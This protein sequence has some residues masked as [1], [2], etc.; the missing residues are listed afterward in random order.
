M[1]TIHLAIAASVSAVLTVAAPGLAQAEDAAPPASSERTQA[2]KADAPKEPVKLPFREHGRIGVVGALTEDM[3]K[4]GLVFEHENFELQVLAHAGP[5]GD[6]ERDVHI[7]MKAGGRINL[8]TL[9]YLALG[10]E[11]GPH[12]GSREQGKDIGGTFQAGP[13]IS[14][15]RYFAATPVMLVLW[16]NP[17]QYDY[18]VAADGAGGVTREGHIRILQS[19]GFGLAYLF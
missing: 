1:R 11:Y 17:I 7:I 15:E 12:P 5:L 13:Y 3:W 18:Q 19:G 4:G 10:A 16:V 8:G 6:Q 2:P 14:L 9:N